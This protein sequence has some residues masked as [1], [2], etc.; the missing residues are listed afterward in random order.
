MRRKVEEQDGSATGLRQSPAGAVEHLAHI[1]DAGAHRG[2]GYELAGGL[3]GDHR[4]EGRLAGP[5]RSPQH[6]RRQAVRLDQGPQRC[7]GADQM[8]LA[9][10]LVEAVGPHPGGERGPFGHALP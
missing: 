7:A 2:E 10:D 4:R 8:A 1:L 9:D 3:R 5:G 6:D